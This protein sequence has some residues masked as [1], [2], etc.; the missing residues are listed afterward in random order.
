MIR[1]EQHGKGAELEDAMVAGTAH[2]RRMVA[3]LIWS[4]VA[5]G[6]EHCLALQA[7]QHLLFLFIGECRGNIG[8]MRH[9]VNAGGLE[10]VALC[11]QVTHSRVQLQPGAVA[12]YH[13]CV[14]LR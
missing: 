11:W 7:Q 8:S 9:G 14:R 12:E 2:S 4:L 1:G 10:R 13:G 5:Q 3:Y 6:E